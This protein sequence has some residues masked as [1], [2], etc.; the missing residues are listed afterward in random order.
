MGVFLT[1]SIDC[2]EQQIFRYR[3][4]VL[5]KKE[6]KEGANGILNSS[7]INPPKYAPHILPK[8]NFSHFPT[9]L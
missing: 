1:K 4:S 5:E 2:R 8:R 6:R 9:G 7:I 3:F